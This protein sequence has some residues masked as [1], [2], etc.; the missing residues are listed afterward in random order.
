LLHLLSSQDLEHYGALSNVLKESYGF[1][2][3][4]ALHRV[5]IDLHYFIA[6]RGFNV[7]RITNVHILANK[8][9]T[10]LQCA[11]IGCLSRGKY[12]LDKDS[13]IALGRVPASH[14][15]EAQ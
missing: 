3:T 14:Y 2:M 12:G 15:T 7:V 8:K 13:H 1:G 10:R 4:H 6:C 11:I 9:L 5:A